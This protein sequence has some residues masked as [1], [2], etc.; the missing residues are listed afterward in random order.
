MGIKYRITGV[1]VD[2]QKFVLLN[3]HVKLNNCET[4]FLQIR[5]GLEDS[6]DYRILSNSSYDVCVCSNEAKSV[7]FNIVP[8]KLGKMPLKVVAKD[9]ASSVCQKG[10]EQMTLGVTDAVI[11]K[12]LV[13]V[14]RL[15]TP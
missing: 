1:E 14:C 7:R 5:L 12:L 10:I 8:K 15:L 11:R 13:E 4:L 3:A 6:L 9:V 2:F